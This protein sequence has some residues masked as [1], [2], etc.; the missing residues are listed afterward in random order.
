VSTYFRTFQSENRKELLSKG[1]DLFSYKEDKDEVLSFNSKKEDILSTTI[2]NTKDD[3]IDFVNF[4]LSTIKV[5]GWKFGE[6]D[7]HINSLSDA[8]LIK[9]EQCE[10]KLNTINELSL[11]SFVSNEIKS[12]KKKKLFQKYFIFIGIGFVFLVVFILYIL[13]VLK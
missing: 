13:G 9:L 8:C 6:V 5:N 11:A 3:I 12:L 2:P 4:L 7:K 1:L 10:I